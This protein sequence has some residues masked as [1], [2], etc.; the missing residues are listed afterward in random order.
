MHEAVQEAH[1][2]FL[3]DLKHQKE[4]H[5]QDREQM[6]DELRQMSNELEELKVLNSKKEQAVGDKEEQVRL[7]KFVFSVYIPTARTLDVEERTRTADS[8]VERSAG[9]GIVASASR[10]RAQQRSTIRSTW[11]SCYCRWHSTGERAVASDGLRERQ[12]ASSLEKSF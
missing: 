11:N 5:S 9:R 1:Q 3:S 8:G 6:K 7:A 12:S 2:K 10:I 4:K